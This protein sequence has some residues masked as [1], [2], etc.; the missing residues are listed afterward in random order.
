M[1]TIFSKTAVS[2][3]S[4]IVIAA[5]IV[6]SVDS[7]RKAEQLQA[8][9]MMQSQ[10]QCPEIFSANYGAAISNLFAASSR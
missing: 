1:K 8:A 10:Q 6:L 7:A 3:L 5:L 4:T 2:I 9:A